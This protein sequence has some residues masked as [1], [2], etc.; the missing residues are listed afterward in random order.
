MS[1]DLATRTALS[2]RQVVNM[3]TPGQLTGMELYDVL[4]AGET[5][6]HNVE[7]VHADTSHGLVGCETESH[8]DH[9][10]P[11]T[12]A[13][14]RHDCCLQLNRPGL[15]Y[16]RPCIGQHAVRLSA[17][18]SDFSTI[19]QKRMGMLSVPANARTKLHAAAQRPITVMNATLD[20]VLPF[21]KHSIGE[22]MQQE[23]LCLDSISA[24][25]QR[26]LRKA[27]AEELA[28]DCESEMLKHLLAQVSTEQPVSVK[29]ANSDQQS[30]IQFHFHSKV[31]AT[32]DEVLIITEHH[33][34][35][36]Y[37]EDWFGHFVLPHGRLAHFYY[38][39]CSWTVHNV[40]CMWVAV[41]CAIQL[42][43]FPAQQNGYC[44]TLCSTKKNC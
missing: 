3:N 12:E 43:Y 38:H 37:C 14:Q 32:R 5:L 15:M 10:A 22:S 20:D 2:V 39:V 21:Q 6:E 28:A 26:L 44:L 40:C 41:A 4:K 31:F 29:V 35:A 34:G 17:R 11:A 42:I 1:P 30:H 25:E 18:C 16:E 36:K 9:D 8:A 24:D 33:D 19:I 13:K 23:A 27:R 7:H